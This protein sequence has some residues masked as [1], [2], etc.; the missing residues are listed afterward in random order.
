MDWFLR[1]KCAMKL[2]KSIR[3]NQLYATNRNCHL[4]IYNTNQLGVL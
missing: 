2:N 4:Q 1:L 3:I